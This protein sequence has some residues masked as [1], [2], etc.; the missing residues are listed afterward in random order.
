[1]SFNS[2]LGTKTDL[3]HGPNVVSK[4]DGERMKRK[5]NANQFLGCSAKNYVNINEVVYEAVRA[6]TVGRPDP[7]TETYFDT[8][9]NCFCCYDDEF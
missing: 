9:R 7:P 8:L 6:A 2:P 5:I 1:M 3:N 4:A